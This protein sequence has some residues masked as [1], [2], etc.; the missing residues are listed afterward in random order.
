M[1]LRLKEV[2]KGVNNTQLIRQHGKY[3]DDPSGKLSN[4]IPPGNF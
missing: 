1:F 2:Q 3:T 4:I